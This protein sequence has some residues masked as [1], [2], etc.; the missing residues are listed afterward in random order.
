MQQNDRLTVAD[1]PVSDHLQ[2]PAKGSSS[3]SMASSSTPPPLVVR[4]ASLYSAI[5]KCT[6]SV[7]PRRH[8]QLKQLSHLAHFVAGLFHRLFTNAGFRLVVVQQPGAGFNQHAVMIA[9][10]PVATRN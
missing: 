1:L 10:D 9:I 7:T 5:K 2:R 6:T 4:C 3:T 8:K